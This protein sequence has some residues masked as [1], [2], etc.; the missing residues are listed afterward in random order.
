MLEMDVWPADEGPLTR[1]CLGRVKALRAVS[2][3]EA[4][5][6]TVLRADYCHF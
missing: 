4:A 6:A 1:S 5:A 2:L 3:H